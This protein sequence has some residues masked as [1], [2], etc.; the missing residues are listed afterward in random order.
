MFLCLSALCLIFSGKWKYIILAAILFALANWIRPLGIIFLFASVVYFVITKAKFYNYIAL[1]IPYIFVLF[2]IG[3]ITEKKIGYFAYQSTTSGVNLMITSHDNAIGNYM[4]PSHIKEATIENYEALTFAEKDSIW[5]DRSFKWIKA[6]PMKFVSL[7]CR[8]ILILY[9]GDGWA[10]MSHWSHDQLA[11]EVSKD[12]LIK[13][14]LKQA[15]LSV[16]YYLA[17][18]LFFYCMWANRKQFFT[19]KSVFLVI[20]VTGTI[21]TC[22]FTVAI[23]YHYP[24]MFAVILYAAYG[25]DTL[26]ERKKQ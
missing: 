13:R 14:L 21:I 26:L 22:I 11:Y 2:T 18:L 6:N 24:F 8:K 1:I 7:Y 20:F 15:L 19:T 17:F 10:G 25:V 16:T 3:T 5:K 12:T 9:Y 23:R 4:N